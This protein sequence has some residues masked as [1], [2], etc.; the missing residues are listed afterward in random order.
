MESKA[1]QKN[2]LNF[3]LE[4]FPNAKAYNINEESSLLKDKIIDSLGILTIIQFLEEEFGVII[5]DE[6]V[7]ESNFNSIKS[8]TSFINSKIKA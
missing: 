8:I 7:D 6:E 3:I 4:N 5:K 1:I 2:I